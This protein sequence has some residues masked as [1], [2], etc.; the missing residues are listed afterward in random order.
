MSQG[1][2]PGQFITTYGPGAVL[3]GPGGPR[4]IMSIQDSG[5]F[6]NRSPRDFQ[7]Q[8]PALSTLLP[9]R[10]LIFRLPSNAELQRPDL[11]PVYETRGFP[12][13]SLCVRHNILYRH[14]VG[15][16]RTGCPQC[17]TRSDRWEAYRESRREAIRFVMACPAGHLDEV[18]WVGLIRHK[19]PG[20]SP[21][22]LRWKASGSS[23]RGVAV[24]CPTC[25]QSF[26]LGEAYQRTFD[27]RGARPEL[28]QEHADCRQKAR[29]TQRGAANLFIPEVLSAVTIPNLDT[30][31]HQAL[32]SVQC[33]LLL[34]PLHDAGKLTTGAALRD[35]LLK[36]ARHL[37][38]AVEL[39]VKKYSD[40]ALLR[41]ARDVLAMSLPQTP[42][43]QRA[44]E[45]RELQR[46]ATHGHP[47]STPGRVN[48][49]PDFE[50]VAQF[51]CA[52]PLRGYSLRVTPVSRLRVV[53]V[54]VGYRR[55]GGEVA[56]S[57]YRS[58]AEV[59]FPGTELYGE[60]V[61]LDLEPLPGAES[62]I[63]H[64]GSGPTWA[65]WKKRYDT[66]PDPKTQDHPVFVWWHTLAHRLIRSL[67]VDSGYSS[68]SVRERVYF[69]ATRQGAVGGV[70]LYAVQPGGDGTLGGLIAL[71]PA[72]DR[73]LARATRDL[74]ACS[75]DPLC[76][77]TSIRPGRVNG[78]AC[79][80]CSLVS[81]TSC[82]FRN[83]SLDRL[84]LKE[85]L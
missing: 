48:V 55:L 60:G 29:I 35:I 22:H 40:D 18:N 51:V 63:D 69:Q 3:E 53:M 82:E 20:C 7:I 34:E 4:V 37:P 31:L 9:E 6:Q 24:Q 67:S 23:L 11:D 81:E 73:V 1:I 85:T 49:P 21:D 83:Q 46:A 28:R 10:A 65:R 64:P 50:V 36:Y 58:G 84:I 5:L 78:A 52:F 16:N 30:S 13:W 79:Y 27:C 32:G 72:F 66:S 59:W 39:E 54:Q 42:E 15:Q 56:S 8:E 77:E 2:R 33:K 44:N 61:F 47:P 12:V 45:F 70:L 74:D 25:Q 71:V 57:E 43:E 68:A 19:A 17:G 26:N 38:P 41:A 62:A 14:R 80:A 76:E 75:N